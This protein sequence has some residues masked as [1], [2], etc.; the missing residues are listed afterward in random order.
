MLALFMKS[1]R[2]C[3]VVSC[4]LLAFL[5]AILV[6][7]YRIIIE[8]LNEPLSYYVIHMTSNA[9][10]A[11][12]IET[13]Q[14]QLGHPIAVFEAVN[15]RALKGDDDLLQFDPRLKTGNRK[16][17]NQRVVGAELGC[18]LSHFMLLK[19]IAA[20]PGNSQYSVILEDDF[21]LEGNTVAR[22][23]QRIVDTL[24]DDGREAD[25]IF[26]GTCSDN[27]GEPYKDNIREIQDLSPSVVVMCTHGYIVKNSSAEHIYSKLFEIDDPIDYKFNDM[28]KRGDIKA[29]VIIPPVV[30]QQPGVISSTLR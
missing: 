20:N 21:K 9:E 27:T 7:N 3:L 16:T 14:T 4:V 6:V 18:Y 11:A 15:G 2:Q 29:Y 13:Q 30:E 28:I 17:S 10:R 23:I 5:V 8:N 1:W 19:Q 24:V 12:N 22:D 26:L 25:I